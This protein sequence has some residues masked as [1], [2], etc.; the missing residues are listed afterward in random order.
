MRKKVFGRKLG[1]ERD[2]RRGLFRS[3][4][5]SLIEHGKIKT[6]QAKAKAL[7]PNI[8]KM[9]NLAKEDDLNA[10]RKLF[11]MLGGNKEFVKK[12]SAISPRMSA[13]RSGYTRIVKIGRRTGD[14]APLVRLEWVDNVEEKKDSSKVK[15]KKPK[16]SVKGRITKKASELKS[17]SSATKKEDKK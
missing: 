1:R 6:T 12:L 3:L 2:S 4:A 15:S 16:G 7:L 14:A 9:V 17:K 11:S 10:K 5:I 8:D 13:R